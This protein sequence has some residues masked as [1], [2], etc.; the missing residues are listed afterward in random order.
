MELNDAES[1]ALDFPSEERK[2]DHKQTNP[3]KVKLM[4][5]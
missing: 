1:E 2:L 5:Y 4:K 3:T